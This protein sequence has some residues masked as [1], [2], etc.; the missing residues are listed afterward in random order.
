MNI[1]YC[2]FVWWCPGSGVVLDCIDSCLLCYIVL[3]VSC[4]IV[5][6]CWERA[7]FLVLLYVI[8]YYVCHFPI[9][10]PGSGVVLGCIDSC[11]LPSSLLWHLI[12]VCIAF[13]SSFCDRKW[14]LILV[15]TG[16]NLGHYEY[17]VSRDCFM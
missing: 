10:Y 17:K 11:S 8:L 7:D 1:F 2:V 9:Q 14:L 4:S 6:T 12:Y 16:S 15:Y 13:F 5:V 3:S